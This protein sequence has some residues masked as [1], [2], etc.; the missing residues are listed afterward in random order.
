MK[1]R[2][3]ERAR[4]LVLRPF[5]ESESLG[6]FFGATISEHLIICTI[7]MSNRNRNTTVHFLFSCSLH[8]YV[9]AG[10]I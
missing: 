1:E 7:F 5:R 3:R 2:E 10:S 6:R 9:L 8:E 4:V